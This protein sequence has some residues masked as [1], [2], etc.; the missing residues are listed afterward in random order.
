MTKLLNKQISMQ[1]TVWHSPEIKPHNNAK[2]RFKLKDD[3]SIYEGLYI[4]Q[5]DM[6]FVGFDNESEHFHFTWKVEKW[7]FMEQTIDV[8]KFKK[9][10]SAVEFLEDKLMNH[11]YGGVYFPHNTKELFEQAKSIENKQREKAFIEGYKN[12]ALLSNLIFDEASKLFAKS[13]F[14]QNQTFKSE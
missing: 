13:L 1:V 6:F 3:D 2:I 8:R 12:R 5:E 7:S 11:P 10:P 14:E 4:E 9:E